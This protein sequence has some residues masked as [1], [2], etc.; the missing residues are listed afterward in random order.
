MTLLILTLFIL[1]LLI[2]AAILFFR[3]SDDELDVDDWRYAEE[4]L[5]QPGMFKNTDWRCVKIRPGLLSCKRANR[6]ADQLFLADE[7]PPLPLSGC[8]ETNCTCHYLHFGDRRFVPE[9]RV[10][11]QKLTAIFS[12]LGRD[13]GRNPAAD[14]PT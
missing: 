5:T 6:L 4:D 10:K 9:R 3:S 8:S 12:G 11:V 1:G 7:A 2:V 14:P 13:L